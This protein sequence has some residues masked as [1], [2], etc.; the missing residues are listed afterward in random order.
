MLLPLPLF[1]KEI[2]V[3]LDILLVASAHDK[4]TYTD[5]NTLHV[6]FKD[7][8]TYEIEG[9]GKED[10]EYYYETIDFEEHGGVLPALCGISV[11]QQPDHTGGAERRL[12]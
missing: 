12:L 8:N 11:S 2:P 4:H 3:K 1:P 7:G 9:I 5:G 10:I 6:T